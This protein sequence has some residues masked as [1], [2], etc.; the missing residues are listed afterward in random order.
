M[1][2]AYVLRLCMSECATR[3]SATLSSAQSASP[4]PG[5]IGWCNGMAFLSLVSPKPLKNSDCGSDFEMFWFLLHLGEK[6][7]KKAVHFPHAFLIAKSNRKK[8]DKK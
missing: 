7:K 5:C 2:D 3:Y 8:N 4:T 1:S 6:K